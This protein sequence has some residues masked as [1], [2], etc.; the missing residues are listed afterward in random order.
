MDMAGSCYRYLLILVGNINGRSVG[1][2]CL[3]PNS[4][5]FVIGPPIS[6]L[7]LAH[8]LIPLWA[9]LGHID[10]VQFVFGARF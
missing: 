4:C 1:E 9:K 5:F 3:R 2:G 8:E 6:G 7:D 10:R